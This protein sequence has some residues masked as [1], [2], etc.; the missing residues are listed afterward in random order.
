MISKGPG[1]T[2][3]I[4]TSLSGSNNVDS[5]AQAGWKLADISYYEYVVDSDWRNYF[6]DP[7]LGVGLAGSE[8]EPTTDE[9]D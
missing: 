5:G 6:G 2:Q 9:Y 7:V 1:T 3:D 8:V 4:K